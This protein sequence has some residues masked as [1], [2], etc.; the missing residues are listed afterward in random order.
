MPHVLTT[1][2][3]II[4][5]IPTGFFRSVWPTIPVNSLVVMVEAASVLILMGTI[6]GLLKKMKVP[7]LHFIRI[8]SGDWKHSIWRDSIHHGHKIFQPSSMA[9]RW[10]GTQIQVNLVFDRLV[11]P[12]YGLGFLTRGAERN[13]RPDFRLES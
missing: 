10:E 12:T 7:F 4:G 11:D 1:T 2:L 6:G 9:D 8:E 5:E 13:T 3:L